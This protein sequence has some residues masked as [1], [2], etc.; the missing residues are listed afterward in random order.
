V[1]QSKTEYELGTDLQLF[2]RL[3]INAT[4]Y[5]S[6]KLKTVVDVPLNG[7]STFTGLYGNFATIENKNRNGI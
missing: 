3:N 4:Y 7:S 6:K 1:R 2:K 5:S